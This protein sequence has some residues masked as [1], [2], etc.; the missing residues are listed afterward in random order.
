MSYFNYIKEMFLIF[1]RIFINYYNDKKEFF[2]LV[3]KNNLEDPIFCKNFKE[4]SNI[5]L[6]LLWIF[7]II[8]LLWI[9]Y[10]IFLNVYKYLKMSTYQYFKQNQQ[11]N[12]SPLLKQLESIYYLNDYVIFDYNFFLF[13]TTIIFILIKIEI[14][15]RVSKNTTSLYYIKL[16]SY[17]TL[18]I[19]VIYYLIN[20]NSIILIGKGINSINRLI[21]SN[22]NNEFINSQKICNYLFKKNDYDFDFSYGKC[23]HLRENFNMTKLYKY[24]KSL[25]SEIE[26]TKAPLSNLSVEEFKQLKDKNGRLYKDKIVSAFFTFQLLKYFVDNDLIEE[27]KTFFSAFNTIYTPN[28]NLLR[29][30]INP[31]LYFRLDNMLL[32]DDIYSF[33]IRMSDSFNNNKLIYNYIYGEYYKIQDTIQN[34]V[35]KVFNIA[36]KDLISIY[37]Y[38]F[39]LLIVIIILLI[40]SYLLG[41]KPITTLLPFYN[42]N[43]FK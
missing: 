41:D 19:S 26:Q 8:S 9:L 21:Y 10:D 25:I 12:D 27:A 20:Y 29:K 33:D 37:V 34:L 23:N 18:I 5:I 6:Y 36:N 4:V 16:F 30:K 13:V 31:I 28:V 32:F 2:D 17:I 22:I 39:I 15:E 24:I 1:M 40:L 14:F 7:L 38:Y 35:I 42:Q 11:F 3:L 43:F